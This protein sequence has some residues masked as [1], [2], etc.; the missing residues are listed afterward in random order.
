M[1]KSLFNFRFRLTAAIFLVALGATVTGL[2]YYYASAKRQIWS[3]MTN[4]VKD[5]GK[6]GVSLLGPDDLRYLE[7]LDT[8]LNIP[9][10]QT[11]PIPIQGQAFYALADDEKTKIIR[12]TPFQ[13]IVQKLRRLRYASGKTPVYEEILPAGLQATAEPQIHRAWIAGLRMHVHA[14]NFLRVLCA[15]EFEEIDR[16]QNQKIDPEESIYHI[17]DIFNSKG[18]TG[19]ASALAGEVAVGSGY[20]TES[21]GVFISGY[22][23]LKNARG[24]LVALLVIDFSAATEFDALFRLKV[25]GYYIIIAALLFS[26][27]AAALT[28]RLLLRPLDA[29]QKAAVRIG[30]RDFSVRV[31]MQSRDELADLAFALN[32]MASELG[33][34]STQMERRIAARTSEISG[35]LEA[36][37]QGILTVDSRGLIQ[38][39]F[40][41]ATL[42]IFGVEELAN[43]KFSTLFESEKLAVAI[44]RFIDLF[45]SRDDIS[46]QMLDKA[47]PLREIQ[48]V[49]RKGATKHLRFSFRPLFAD[50]KRRV[51]RLL[52]SI[53]DDTDEAALR[54]KITLAESQQRSELDALINLVRIPS[55]ILEAFIA[56]QSAFLTAGKNLIIRFDAADQQLVSAFAQQVHA[57]KGNALQLRFDELAQ[58]L[59]QIEDQLETI[60]RNAAYDKRFVRHE[61]SQIL[62]RCEQMIVSRETLVLRIRHLMGNSE[63]SDPDARLAKI[64]N[65]W[66]SKIAERADAAKVKVIGDIVFAPGTER[67]VSLLH[68][69]FVQ[70]LRNTFAHGI[71]TSGARELKGKRAQMTVSLNVT[72]E[73]N[74]FHAV[75][76]EDGRGFSQ[77][78]PGA[79]LTLQDLLQNGLTGAPRSATLEAGRGLGM[80]FIASSIQNLGGDLSITSK[81]KETIIHI[82]LPD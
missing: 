65:F 74:G 69:V 26:I 23:P 80:D 1:L 67:A 62:N 3:Q 29:M 6:I 12:A 81:D 73:A 33:E 54:E 44:D 43:R 66:L 49:N 51:I 70:L 15:D 39:E 60:L 9:A 79:T 11:Q 46:E 20:R 4:R 27:M 22:T 55:P 28:S 68:N 34:Y 42:R 48:H 61:L 82:T 10:K 31:E 53:V 8:K 75:Y 58:L 76:T 36:L 56:Q 7:K 19:I 78:A 21:S 63:D 47:N 52:V 5:F 17:G 57:L 40:S 2:V 25:T 18:L 77:I 32:L 14:P 16:N 30:Q 50:H 37:E 59:H 24:D 71:E 64:R 35:I 13:I 38:S 45:F 72:R 41:G